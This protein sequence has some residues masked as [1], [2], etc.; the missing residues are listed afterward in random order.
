MTAYDK[1]QSP[2][3]GGVHIKQKYKGEFRYG[4]II[5]TSETKILVQWIN[6]YSRFTSWVKSEKVERCEWSD[7]LA[8]RS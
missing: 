6:R 3:E 5:Y 7:E 8:R 2:L 4:R 1:Y